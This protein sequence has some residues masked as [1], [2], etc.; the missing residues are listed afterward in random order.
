MTMPTDTPNAMPLPEAL[1][2]FRA[3]HAGDPL[4][5]ADLLRVKGC[6]RFVLS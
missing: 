4:P 2:V 5:T 3:A 1:R 6:V